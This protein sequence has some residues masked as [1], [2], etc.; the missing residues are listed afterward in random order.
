MPSIL[1]ITNSSEVLNMNVTA[2]ATQYLENTTKNNFLELDSEK[3][4]S[5]LAFIISLGAVILLV[6]IIGIIVL[7]KESNHTQKWVNW[8]R[9][10]KLGLI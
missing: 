3:S 8:V 2:I 4:A 9:E 6:I 1:N 7:I 10:K 5:Q